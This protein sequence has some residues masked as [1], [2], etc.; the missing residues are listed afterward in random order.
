MNKLNYIPVNFSHVYYRW[1][2]IQQLLGQRVTESVCV[3]DY[4][5]GVVFL[6][7]KS[8]NSNIFAIWDTNWSCRSYEVQ[9]FSSVFYSFYDWFKKRHTVVLHFCGF[10]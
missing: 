2:C 3:D 1:I 6:L 4:I 9:S 5:A 10:T 7:K 8:K